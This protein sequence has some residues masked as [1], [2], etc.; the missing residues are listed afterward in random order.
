MADP[1]SNLLSRLIKISQHD[2]SLSRIRAEKKKLETELEAKVQH[3]KKLE[4]ELEKRKKLHQERKQKYSK[5]EKTLK[6]EQAKLVDR[7]K[8]LTTL[9]SYKLQQAAE[10]EIEAAARQL[11]MREEAA[12]K[13]LDE[14]ETIESEANQI[15]RGL[16]TLREQHGKLLLESKATLMNLE[17]R[18][19]THRKGREEQAAGVDEANL[20]AYERIY[21]K[22]P[23][24]AVQP[25]KGGTCSGCHIQVAPQILVQIAKG[26]ALVRC[27]GCGRILYLE[28]EQDQA[29]A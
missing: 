14:V 4:T 3:I 5:E 23:M 6:E 22:F 18:E 7:R 17:E 2:T 11:G 27:R 8:A 29:K 1:H 16:E 26:D 12:I 10:K 24:G 19:A 20:K 9:S 15:T 21:E 25:V 28:N 13:S